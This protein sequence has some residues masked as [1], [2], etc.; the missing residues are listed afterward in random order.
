LLLQRT[1][2]SQALPL[3]LANKSRWC[4]DCEAKVLSPNSAV[5]LDV[6]LIN[7]AIVAK[8]EDVET[9]DWGCARVQDKSPSPCDDIASVPDIEGSDLIDAIAGVSMA[10]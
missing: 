2:A 8:D 1:I 6:C 5:E 10:S 9:L 4:R 7:L 3:P